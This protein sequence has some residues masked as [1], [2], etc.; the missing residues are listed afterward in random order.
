MFWLLVSVLGRAC[1]LSQREKIVLGLPSLMLAG[2]GDPQ[3][4]ARAVHRFFEDWD[5]LAKRK[6]KTGTHVKPYG[7]APYYFLYGHLYCAQAIEQLVDEKEKASLRERLRQV[8][9]KSRDDDGSWNDRQFG[10][11]GGYGTAVAILVM[12]MQ[13]VPAPCPWRPDAAAAEKK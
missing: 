3:R 9:A 1:I 5:E 10:R 13:H 6:S 11:S 8:L 7:I 2:R 4:L 12:R